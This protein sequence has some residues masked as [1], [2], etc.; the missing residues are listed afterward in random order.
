MAFTRVYIQ[1]GRSSW[2][3]ES[4]KLGP[5]MLPNVNLLCLFALCVRGHS[6][7][8]P[9]DGEV[10]QSLL[11]SLSR[12]HWRVAKNTYSCLTAVLYIFCILEPL[13]RRGW[14]WGGHILFCFFVFAKVP[15]NI[16]TKCFFLNPHLLSNVFQPV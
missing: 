7:P 5:L 11:W 8:N 15:G 4:C 10:Y 2:R 13:L 1:A 12:S 16:F 14:G 3:I 9:Q 6:T